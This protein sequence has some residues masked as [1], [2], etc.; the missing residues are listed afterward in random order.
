M[1]AFDIVFAGVVM[2]GS[3][4]IAASASPIADA[5]MRG[6]KAAVG[7]LLRQKADVNAPQPDGATAIQWAA[8]KNDLAMADLLIS[9]G[10]NVKTPN[11]VAPRRSNW[12]RSMEARP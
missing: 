8:Y 9:A 11:R 7:N 6:D 5:A 2:A 10:A 3:N 1:R 12:P 4:L